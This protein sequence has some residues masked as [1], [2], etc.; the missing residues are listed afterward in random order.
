MIDELQQA[1]KEY[2]ASWQK[3]VSNRNDQDFFRQLK[4]TAV[5]WKMVDLADFNRRFDELRDFCDQIH[6]GWVN[7]RWL[8]TLHLKSARLSW[9]ISVVKLMQRRPGSTDAVGLDHV[10]WLMPAKRDGRAILQ[11]EQDLKWSEEK[12]GSYSNWL[13]VWF[14]D[15]E[16]K[17]RTGTTLGVCAAELQEVE[18]IIM[19]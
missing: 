10:D 5:A 15:T 17:L 16:A 19:E 7:E 1:L 3:L 11:G 4:P 12:N 8:A 14:A 13:S 9:Q 6:L 2:Q 18:K